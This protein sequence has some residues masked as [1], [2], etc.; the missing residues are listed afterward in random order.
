[1][2]KLSW[3][4]VL[5]GLLVVDV[6]AAK[7]KIGVGYDPQVDFSQY[8]TYSWAKGTSAVNEQ[9][10]QHVVQTIETHLDGKGLSRVEQGGDLAVR[11]HTLAAD[12]ALAGG[13]SS[14]FDGFIWV[15]WGGWGLWFSSPNL[16]DY[17]FGL[18]MITLQ[19]PVSE[20]TV[21]TGMAAAPMMNEVK[22]AKTKID[23][24]AAKLFQSYPPPKR[25]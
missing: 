14:G 10:Q 19:D 16:R 17:T 2:R 23:K 21:W 25:R 4:A 22:K 24:I 5:L 13:M 6:A 11:S 18:L 8:K 1:M 20:E 9:I 3:L 7:D 15:G 12:V